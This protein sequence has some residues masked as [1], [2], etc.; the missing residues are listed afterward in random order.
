MTK[1][2]FLLQRAR[3]LR[4]SIERITCHVLHNLVRHDE[5]EGVI[6]VLHVEDTFDRTASLDVATIVQPDEE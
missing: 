6:R 5:V 3:C 4:E 1:D 2:T